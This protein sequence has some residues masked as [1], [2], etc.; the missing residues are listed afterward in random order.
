[1]NALFTID[2][3][4]S[5]ISYRIFDLPLYWWFAELRLTGGIHVESEGISM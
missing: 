5:W 1:M 4:F 3:T 2:M